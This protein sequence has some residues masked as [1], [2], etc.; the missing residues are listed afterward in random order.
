MSRTLVSQTCL[1]VAA[2]AVAALAIVRSTHTGTQL[3]AT[4]AHGSKHVSVATVPVDAGVEAVVVLDHITLELTGY[5]M[6]PYT[7][8]FFAGYYAQLANEFGVKQGKLPEFTLIAGRANFRQFTGNQRPADG[9]V[10]VAEAL[11]GKMIAY[12]I[13]WDST[14]RSN[15]PN[16]ARARFIPLDQTTFRTI[17]IPQP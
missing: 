6:N 7:G 10:Y 1:A 5:I 16:L 9:V 3:H 12:G 17:P 11:S 15:P 14:F 2:V 13:P 8:K 4:A